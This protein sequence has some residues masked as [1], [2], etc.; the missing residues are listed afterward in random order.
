METEFAVGFDIS[1]TLAARVAMQTIDDNGAFTSVSNG[2]NYGD[3]DTKSG[4][5]SCCGSQMIRL[6]LPLMCILLGVKII[7]QP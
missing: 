3:D 6:Q 2:K 1:D 5:V 7:V 4:R